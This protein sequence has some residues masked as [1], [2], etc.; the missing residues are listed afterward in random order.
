MLA[1]LLH[2]GFG[3]CPT[4]HKLNYIVKMMVIRQDKQ[5]HAKCANLIIKPHALALT[6][7]AMYDGY[8]NWQPMQFALAAD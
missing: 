7:K 2:V 1:L 4:S 3:E 8:G 5:T 6:V